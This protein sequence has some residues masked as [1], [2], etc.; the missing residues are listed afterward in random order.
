[1]PGPV[2]ITG[3]G[4]GG[5]IFPMSAIAD[6]L[7]E[8]G[9]TS[10]D[11]RFV[12]S[13]R[14]QERRLLAS[15][16][17]ELTL[18]GGRGIVRSWRPRAVVANVGAVL[19]LVGAVAT[20][21]SLVGRLR[22]SV[23]VS[24]G[25]YA[26]FAVSAAAIV[27]RRPLVLVE[28]DAVPGAS[29]RF[30]ARFAR[31][32]CCAFATGDPTAVV[33]GTPLR[34]DIVAVDRSPRARE[35]ARGS[36]VPPIEPQRLVVVVMTGSL[37]SNRVNQAVS[38]LAGLWSERADVTIVH[39][40]GRRDF[41]EMNARQPT[42]LGL[43]YRLVEFADMAELWSVCDL[44][45][46]RAGATTVAELATL[47]I[48]SILVPL[49]GAPGD[50]QTKNARALVEAGGALMIADA[51]CTGAAVARA[52]DE[53]ATP[54]RRARMSQSALELGRGDATA[55]IARVVREVGQW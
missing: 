30:L 4:T 7:I 26:S 36:M 9:L 13:R 25:G 50:H 45:V 31:V 3:G 28:L 29:Q 43:D 23:V 1:M 48:P 52:I 37:G 49:P 11:L 40:T 35:A 47:G 14:G 46:C 51:D 41:R 20:A 16:G 38:E 24:V 5:H 10:A 53:I 2:I 22:P 33:T 27:R 42:T 17:I 21:W 19:G 55:T 8:D 15:S 34:A 32:R 54:E 44:A 39:V 18:L 6:R 12:G